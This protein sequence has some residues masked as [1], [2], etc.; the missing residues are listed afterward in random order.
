MLMQNF[1]NQFFHYLG[2]PENILNLFYN[3]LQEFFNF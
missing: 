2:N 1:Q 3:Q